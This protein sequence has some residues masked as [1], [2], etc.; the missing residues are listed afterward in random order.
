MGTP[1][2]SEGQRTLMK[3]VLEYL[4]TIEEPGTLIELDMGNG[5]AECEICMA[6]RAS[7][8]EGIELNLR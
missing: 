6:G 4:R 5:E 1:F 2:D 7:I 8:P 3:K